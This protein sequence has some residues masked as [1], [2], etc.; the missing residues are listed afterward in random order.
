MQPISIIIPALNEEKYIPLLLDSIMHARYAGELEVIVVDGGSTDKTCEVV[1]KYSDTISGLKLLKYDRGTSKQRNHGAQHATH[2]NIIFLDAD[3]EISSNFLKKCS[4][5][6]AHGIEFYGMPLILPYD[7]KLIDYTLAPVV[8]LYALMQAKSS[9]I[10]T[11]MCMITT[12][13]VHYKI[14]GFNESMRHAEDLDY[15]LKAFRAG[16]PYKLFLGARIRASVRRLNQ[17]GRIKTM[18]AWLDWHKAAKQQR[19]INAKAVENYSFGD[20]I[21][22]K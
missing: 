1:E 4:E 22:D 20:F 8:Y 5:Y 17:M 11:G 6:F 15:G 18:R 10:L 9:P 13:S 12:K 16:V 14:G 21:D 2:P 7:G 3:T 19:P